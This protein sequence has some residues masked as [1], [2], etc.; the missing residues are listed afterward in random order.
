MKTH[1]TNYFNTFIAVA[2]DCPVTTAE[3]PVA[4]NNEP[5]IASMQFNLIYNHPYQFTSDEVIFECFARKNKIP[6]P[7]KE[8]EWNQFFSKGQSCMR[9]SPLTKRYGWGVHSNADGKIAI[10]AVESEEY[11]ILKETGD[12][13]Q[14]KAMRQKKA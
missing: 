1:T 10:Y 8:A 14:F 7:Q 9:S 11:K 13:K 3:I 2:D 6:N 12:L 5:T 4:R